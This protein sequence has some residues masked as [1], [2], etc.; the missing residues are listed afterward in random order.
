M[1]R[2]GQPLGG[3]GTGGRNGDQSWLGTSG[4]SSRSSSEVGKVFLYGRVRKVYEGSIGVGRR[5]RTLFDL[6]SAIVSVTTDVWWADEIVDI[7][8]EGSDAQ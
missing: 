1:D 7:R 4:G 2:Y 6:C 8:R 3:P 5:P